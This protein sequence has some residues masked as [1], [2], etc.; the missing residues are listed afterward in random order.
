MHEQHQKVY[1]HAGKCDDQ[2]NLKDIIDVAI[3]YTPEGVTYDSSN[4]SMTSTLVK[5]PSARKS[6]CLFTKI[7]D[8]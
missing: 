6:L 4:V 8:F 7:L 5:K 2:K 1:Q 3:L